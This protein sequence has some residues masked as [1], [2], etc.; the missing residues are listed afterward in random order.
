MSARM[1]VTYMFTVDE[2]DYAENETVRRMV[3]QL[4]QY[5]GEG[6]TPA[7]RPMLDANKF[8]APEALDEL[9]MW[10]LT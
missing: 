3:N 8:Y 2:F 5:I 7:G 4:E 1:T 6:D 9:L 10:K